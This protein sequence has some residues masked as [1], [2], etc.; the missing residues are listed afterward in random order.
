MRVIW[1]DIMRP[2]IIFRQ[3]GATRIRYSRQTTRSPGSLHIS[4]SLSQSLVSSIVCLSGLPLPTHLTLT[5]P[6]PCVVHRLPIWPSSPY[7][8]QS[9]SASP[10]CRPSFAYLAFLSLHISLS[11]SQSLVS[12]IVCLSYLALCRLVYP[13][14]HISLSLSQSLVS[15]IVYLSG[16]PLPT[17][18]TLTQPV[19]CVV[20]RLPIWPS[21]PYT[22]HS[23]S[24]SPLCR[25]S[26]AYLAFL[27]LHISLSLSQSLVSSIVCLSGLPL[28]TH[29]T[30]T[31]PVPCVV[32]RLPIWPSSPYTSHSHSAR[33][34]C[35][36]S[37]TYLALLS[38]HI[39]LSLSQSLVSSIVC[40]SGLP[41]PT[42]LTLTQPVPCVVHRLPI[43]PSSPYTSHSHSASPLCR[44][45]FAYLAFLSLHISL[46]LSQ[47]LASRPSFAYLAF[48]SLHISLSLSQSLVSSIVCLS[49]LAL[50]THL[51]L[52]Q[53]V[54]CVVH[55]LP[56]WPSSP[57]TSHSHSA[58]PLCR[59]SFGLPLPTH[60]TLTQPVPC[61]VHR[62]PIWPSSPYTSHSHSASP[63]CRPSFAY[64][65]FLSLHISLSLSQTLVSS[66]VCL[67][68]LA[69]PTHLTLTQPV[70][71]VVHRLPIWPCS[72][73]TSHS[74]SASPLCRPSFAYLAFLS[75]HISLSLSQSLVSS[76][77]CLS[78]LPLPTHLT[79]TQPVP[80][81]VHR[82]PIW[83]SS[84]Y[85]SHSH[86]ASPL[87]RPS[88][89][90][91]AFLSLHISL[92]LSQ[93]LVSSIVCLSGLPLPT[94][95]T[96]TQPV[97][98]VVH[99]LPI[100]PSSPYTSHSHSASPLCRPS[101]AYLAFLSLHISLSLSQSLVSSIVCLSGLPLPTHLSLSQPVPCVVHRLPIWPCS[102]YTSHSH[103]ASPLCRPSF[104]YLALLSLHISLSQ[105]VP[106]VVH[107]L[108]IWP[109]SPYTS[110]SHSASPLCRPSFAYLAF[111]SL[112]I[113]LSLSQ[114]LV[115]SIVYLSGL[116]L[117]THLT[118][119]QP[120]PC[121][122]HRLP[123]WPCSPYTSHSHSAS[124]LCRPSFAYLAFLSLHISL[125]LSQSLVS[126]IVCLSGLPLPTHLTLTQPV[127]C[128][129]HR[130]PIWPSSPYTSQSLSA[131]PLC[132]PS[133]A[134][135]AL[136]SLHISLSLSQSLVSSIVCLSG[137]PLPTHLTLTQPVPCVV[138]RLPIWPS[139]PYTSHSHSASPLCRPSFAYLAFL[140]LHISLSLSQS[141]VSSIVCLSG[142]PLPTHLTLT[143][144][145]PCVVHRLPIWPSPLPT[146]LTLTQP[147]PCVVHRLPIWPCV[148]PY[149][150]HSH[151][152]SPLCRPSF[153][154]LA[155]LSLHI[156]LS[157]SQSLVSSIVCLSGLPLP[158][159][160]T[161]TQPVPCVVHRLPIW[162]C[163]PYT[164]HS[165]SASPL[166]RPSFAYLAFLSLHISLSFSQS[167]V[168]SIVCLSGLALPTHL[169]LTQPVPCVVHRLP[170]WPSSPY[171]SHSHSASPLCRPSFAYLALLSLHISLSFSQSL[172]SSIVCL[173]GLP[174]P[175]H[176][177]LIQPV[178]CVV[179]RLPIWPCSPYTS[180]SHS[181]SPLCRPS[182]AYL[183]FL[184]L[185]IS[186]S[187]SQSLVSSIVCLSGLALPTHLTLTQPVPCVAHSLPIWPS[188]PYT[189]HSHSASPLCR[190]S[191][192]YLAFLSLHI[193]LSLSQ[194]LVS[195][196][197]CLSGLPLPTHLT[198]IQPVPCVVHR[199]PIWPCSPYTSHSHSASPLC[200]PS[201]A[202]LALL[203]LHISLSL[204]QSLVSSIVCLSGLALPTHLTLTQPVPC[205]VHRLPIWPCSPYTSHSHSASP[206]CRPSFAYLVLPL[207]TH[208][209]LT[210]P[211]PCVVHRL[212]IWPSSPYTSHSATYLT[213]TQPVP[214][215]VHR[216]PI[217]PCSPYTSHSHSASP[218]C[219]PSFAYLALLSLHISLSLSQSLVSS[220]VCLSGLALP[221]HLT[222]IQPVPCVVHRLPIW[223]CSPYTSHS[224]SASPLCRLSGLPL[225]ISLSL[226]IWPSSPYTSHSHSASPLCR[227]SF[228]YLAFLSL[229]ISL[230]LSQ[231]RPSPIWPSSPY[232]SHSA[233]PLCRPSFAY[234]A[235]LS[236]HIS[237]SLSQSLVSSIV[238]L[239]GLP[240]PTHLTLTQPVPCVVHRLPIW[241][242]SPYTSHSH[243]ASPLCRPSFAYLALLSLHISLSLSQS[244]VS[245]I[246][247][248]SASPLAFCL[249]LHIS[250]SL[251][252]SLVSSI[253][254]LS[255]LP[256]P[257]HL[258]LTQPVPCVVHRLPIWPSSPYTSHSHSASPLCR[259]SFAYLALLSL[260]ISLS[261]SQSLASSIV[262]L[263][264]LALPTHLTLTQPV[265]C[266]VHRLPIWPC[267]PY[268]SHSHS[269]S[270]LC[271]PSFAYLAFLSLHI[272]LSQSLVSSIV[273]LSG[274]PLPTHLTLTQPVPCVV[275]RLPIWP[276]SPYTSHSHSAS[277][278]CRPS[279]AYLAFLSLHISLSLSQSLVSSIV[280]LSGLPL[281]THLTLTQPVPCVVHR[282]PIWPSSPYTSHSHSASPLCRPSFAYLAL[283]SLHISLSFSQS[284]VSSIV[285]L[286]GL[287]L[288]THLTLI[289]PVPCVVHRL[290]IWPS[291]PYTSHSHSASPL[292]RPSFA[293]LAFLSLHISLSLSQ[294][295]VSSIVCLSGLALPTHLTHQS[296]ASF[297]Y[298]AF[299]SLHISLSLSQS[300]VSSIVCL[301]GL[302]LP[303]HLTL[304]QPVP[305]VVHRLPIWPSSPYTSHSH[306][307][308]PLCRPSFAYLALLSLHISLSQSLASSIVCLSGLPLPTHL[309]LTQPVPCVVHRLPI[310]PCSPYT[311][312]SH[313]ASPLCRPSFTY[314]ALL[315]LHISLSLSQT[316]VSSIVCLSGLPLPTHLTL[317]QPVPCVVH[318]L[319]IWPL[320]I[321]ALLSLHISLSS[322]PVPCVVHRLPIWPCSP[323]TSHSA[324]PLRRPSFAYLAFLSL[325]ISLSLSQSLVSSIVCLSGLPLPTH[326]TL[327]QP[328]PCVVHRLPIW[329]CLSLHISLSLSQSLVSSI[330]CL[331]GLPLPTHLTLTQ[332]DPCVVHRL[333]IWPSSPY[334]SHSHS[335]SPLC[336]PS[337]AYLAFLPT[338]L[339][340]PV[341][342]VV[343]R[344]PIWPCSPYTS[345]S[346]S[347]SP[348]CR[349]S[350]AYLA[351]LSLH[352]SLS[353]SQSLV[354]SIVCL[355]G[356][357]LH[358]SLNQSLPTHLTL[359]QPVPC[360]VHRLPIWP[361]SPYTSHSHSA[362]PLCRPSFAY[363]ALL[364]LHISLSFSQSLV[365]S[366][367]CLSGLPLPTHL[368]LTQP[369]PCVVHRLPI[370]PCSPYTSHSH[371]A[372]PLC[373]PSFAYLALLS[374]HI[375]LSFSQSLVSSIVCLSGLP[376]PTHLTLTQPVPCV[377]HRLPIWPCSPYTSHSHSASPL[378]RP[379]FAYLAFLS[380]HISLSLS[381]SLVSSIVCLSGLALPTHLTLTQPVP[382]VVHRLPIWPCSPYTSHS[383]SASPLCRPSFAYLAFLSLH[384]SLSLS[385][386]LVSSI[387]CLSGLP[388][389]THL[390]LT[391][392]VPCVVH[393]LPIWPS[394]PYTS[395]SHSASPLC[396]PS[397][398]YL[399]FLSLHISLS[400]SQSLVSSIVCLSGLA[401]PTHLT[402]IQPVPCVVHRLPIWPSSPYTSHSHSASPLC[403]PSFAYLALLSLHISLSLSQSL[404]SSIL[405]LS[406]LPLPT[407][408]TLTQPVPCV[409]H[410]LPIWPSSPYTSH[411][412]SA[413]PLCRPSFA[414][415]A[416]LSLHISLSLSQSLV[417]S[418]VCLSGLPL[419]T[420]LTLTQPVPCVVHP[421][422]IWPSS[423]YTSH[424]HSA[425]PLCRPS[426]AYLAFLSLHISLS[427]SQ[428]L[429]S[430]II[431]LSGLPFPTHLTLTQPV[432]CVVHRLPIW[433][434]SPYT[435]HSHSASP[436]CRPS[437]AYLALLSLHISLSL[438][439]SL[440]S[441]I[442]CLS[443]LRL[444]S[445]HISLSLS[446]SLVSSIVCLSGLPLPTHL[447]L[448][449]P[450]PC[451]VHRLP[452]W[453]SS[454]YTSHSHSASPLCRPSFAY[455]AFLSLHISLSLSQSLVSPIVC[456]SGLPLPTH[457]TLTQPVPCVVHR[458]PIWPCS[459]YTSHSHSASPLCRPSFAYLAFL[460]LHISLSL[461]QSLVSSIVCL[462]GL[463]LPTHL[464][465]TQPDPCVVHC[466]PIWPCSP[467][468]SHSHSA[469]P[470]CRPSFAYLAFL[471]LHISLSL[472]QSL[473]SP[474]VCL[475]GLPLPTHLTLIQPVPCVVHRLPIWPSS[476]YTSH[477]HSASP[478]CRP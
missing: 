427:L 321:W 98:C 243:S 148:S 169:T 393:R 269:A 115:S 59:P 1:C 190:P 241:P 197:V 245:S 92:S 181:A 350:F 36:P 101:F 306:S 332:P 288:P 79:L 260:H 204:S 437:F 62:L 6:V 142:L 50:P 347:A 235:F 229:H 452:I 373:R 326:L 477:S 263:S 337:F 146:H 87:C 5:Q 335:A 286:S 453:P 456:L 61:V 60:L 324:S 362:S 213:L 34:L 334:T 193:S 191:F 413:S 158:T 358:I 31:Q 400:L 276:C 221:T 424:S 355:S 398:A 156:S 173:S 392:P 195:P 107:R 227:P 472:S 351:F 37:F 415:L 434:S 177:T 7:T 232:T 132:R 217:W 157:L 281:P 414:Y 69:L 301:S 240:L 233:S 361:S 384:I 431:C 395:H 234:L 154:Y 73:Y 231:S 224:H 145:V 143:Q 471:S 397:F 244:L 451:V 55:R 411:S 262:C 39:S 228:A 86:S 315:S 366:I 421:L 368:T 150:S 72:P 29:L 127:P 462:S 236:L 28:P 377:V 82:L 247:C 416:F 26:F 450:V 372:S 96:L 43:W 289:Q 474:I 66:I 433:P 113:S 189:S 11:L 178:P 140:S 440:V 473:V 357:S 207:P 458:L 446:Q 84:P 370:W 316:L 172:V 161:L 168:S 445:L 93:S 369:V 329:P 122:V 144:P 251:S 383:H 323:Y 35:R 294:S 330:V 287:P 147:V 389:P 100:W 304:T 90:Y 354:S 283:L 109:C 463:A 47:S 343:H 15:S 162:P 32:H 444:L 308:S 16:L 412:H 22:S 327:T 77:V 292:C 436:L 459:P 42:H 297:A 58:S 336:R 129:V 136:L 311:S 131:S 211:V 328:V 447:T 254:C 78:G 212:P 449:Q 14:L 184:S 317:T 280:C 118:L 89:T 342:C 164:S 105:P 171:T 246:V 469:S 63:L 170:I 242:S 238:C 270:P 318:C 468:T 214:C 52:T 271:R 68:G 388:L 363:L 194:S 457:L 353:L 130:L 348:L 418:I 375:S 284:L 44:P 255:G 20:H 4:L 219:R 53:P 210:Q 409:V 230:S 201:F 442:V 192:A 186:L 376:L 250:L 94:H 273:C 454:P 167:L 300:L 256:L 159:H 422:P 149:T 182:F 461:S 56:I 322:Q 365:S 475:S 117:P 179:H 325:H 91:L 432:P 126:S 12:S 331:S 97:P 302:P 309:T 45:S 176:L 345:H 153:A 38:L 333:P 40:L 405:C 364:S 249:S 138:H 199:L 41:L 239:S 344:L 396:R 125:S 261:L 341:P 390:T 202:Y 151:S 187:F 314:L 46:S 406:G 476:P 206:L 74:H 116:A 460:S 438:S 313:S 340:Q 95:L 352:I 296:L 277:P 222:L 403:R 155:L 57:Y 423:P 166:C 112:H 374:L 349:P 23:H 13:G 180:H 196:I 371:S 305:C 279:F 272:S 185:H 464:T 282:L 346:H 81:V 417:S 407:H 18:L 385:Q 120:V 119:T 408:L 216:L 248:L 124:P 430:S 71:C 64:L 2:S 466:L 175:T 225:P 160:L 455:L 9:L 17:H 165:H 70:P 208:L 19:P 441:S 198:L 386:S 128:V 223:P 367:V 478:L 163:S 259:P 293:Y 257:T 381:Q 152:A 104:A 394:S 215:V 299:L 428:S 307:A 51:T 133:F 420:H 80:C 135:L 218:L 435:S 465:L 200:R 274:L 33:P 27:S 137:L 3:S 258:T 253:V 123:I 30:L 102:P 443:G 252:Q 110:H 266:V 404:V 25:P 448:T 85:T 220:I 338:H 439:Q 312:H 267:S 387:V 139:S 382:C 410:R 134:Y 21:S 76:I 470:L 425:S 360:V 226:P 237:L 378:C 291:S 106:C 419:P 188:S 278:L 298:L 295:L 380:L 356:L 108:P 10:L 379:S 339:T 88:F 402:L 114:T 203:S 310:W 320:P 303:T 67:S 121:V 99:R 429:V 174:L 467:Y 54:P 183:A 75:L 111:L 209:T 275:H 49:G 399:A 290:P 103:S 426:F 8:S 391:Q 141:L 319:P 285:C 48:L 24:A 264:G 205:V 268:P 65:A 359:T 401:L 265:P 83:P